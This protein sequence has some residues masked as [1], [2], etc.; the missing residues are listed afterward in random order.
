[1]RKHRHVFRA[2]SLSAFGLSV[3]IAHAQANLSIDPATLT[4]SSGATFNVDVNV[5]NVTDLYGYE[6]DVTFTP[7]VLSAVASSEGSFLTAGGSTFF[8]PGTIDNSGGTVAAT[9]DTLLTA[10]S[11]VSGSGTLATLTFDAIG[12]GTSPLTIQNVQL[13]NSNLNSIL[14]GTT[15][16][17][18]TVTSGT[19]KAPEIDPASAMSGLALLLG[20]LAVLRG[21][22]L[23]N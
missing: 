18:V 1:M 17:S 4:V 20:A 11:G 6:F 19:T 2:L 10:I 5:S 8:I 9:A 13:L 3:S 22:R 7:T 12:G 23:R 14:Y 15:G 16:G 21:R